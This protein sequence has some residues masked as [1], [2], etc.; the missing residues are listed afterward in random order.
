[1]T[2][3]GTQASQI[4]NSYENFDIANTISIWFKEPTTLTNIEFESASS[5]IYLD[6]GSVA[7]NHDLPSLSLTPSSL[8][9]LPTISYTVTGG[10]SGT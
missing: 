5:A 3:L 6:V 4:S 9:P 2:L 7:S 8:D 1:M 10:F